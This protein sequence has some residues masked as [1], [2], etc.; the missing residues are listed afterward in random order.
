MFTLQICCYVGV[1]S[2]LAEDILQHSYL[3]NTQWTTAL[4]L[5]K[6][7]IKIRVFE[8]SS[9]TKH[10]IAILKCINIFLQTYCEAFVTMCINRL[11]AIDNIIWT[12]NE[13]FEIRFLYYMYLLYSLIKTWFINIPSPPS[14]TTEPTPSA[15]ESNKMRLKALE[16]N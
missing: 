5:C 13:V 11:W 8:N 9:I 6:L 3:E 1:E 10:N 7:F 2:H 4:N 16:D 12:W 14:I 15:D